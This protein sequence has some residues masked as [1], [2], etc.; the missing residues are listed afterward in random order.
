MEKTKID[1]F[2]EKLFKIE[3]KIDLAHDI[4]NCGRFAEV[5]ETSDRFF[6]GRR[7]GDI[8]FNVFLGRPSERAIQNTKRIFENLS[9]D[10]KREFCRRLFIQNIRPEDVG[11]SCEK[12]KKVI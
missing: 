2:C 8:G 3:P 7:V 1:P 12:L 9:E 5:T 4:T 11:V 6:F 10:D